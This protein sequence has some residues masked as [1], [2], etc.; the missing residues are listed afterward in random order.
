VKC[1]TRQ[2][3]ISKTFASKAL[4]G[5]TGKIS[6]SYNKTA[7]AVVGLGDKIFSHFKNTLNF[8]SGAFSGIGNFA[9]S[10]VSVMHEGAGT[11]AKN[12]S[13]CI[14]GK[15]SEFHDYTWNT[16]R[17][18]FEAAHK[19][20]NSFWNYLSRLPGTYYRFFKNAA[21]SVFSKITY[22][23]TVI[24]G[25]FKDM[26]SMTKHIVH[27]VQAFSDKT[28]GEI[29]SSIDMAKKLVMS[30]FVKINNLAANLFRDKKP[31][32]T[33][34]KEIPVPVLAE[35]K[36]S[37]ITDLPDI[38]P[39]AGK[40]DQNELPDQNYSVQVVLV[41]NRDA[42]ISS[43]MNGNIASIPYE[44]GTSFNK[45]DI[46]VRFD[47][48]MQKAVYRE[49]KAAADLAKTELE[50]KKQ[51]LD[52]GSLSR[53]ELLAAKG[54][55][56]QKR[57][58]MDQ[59]ATQLTNCAVTAPFD[60]RVTEHL[61]SAYEYAERGRTLIEISAREPLRAQFLVPS[62]WLRWLNIDT[63]LDVYVE[64]SGKT[65]DAKIIRIHGKV[66]PVSQTV[67]IVAEMERYDEELL[68]GM[69]GR[70][71]FDPVKAV[72]AVSRGFLGLRIDNG[73]KFDQQT[74]PAP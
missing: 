9:A 42:V 18:A 36:T 70:A 38:E 26:I 49:R 43:P 44:N 69:S 66:D 16:A 59:A 30:P 53:I 65:Y 33:T 58:R 61:A 4:I 12:A 19:G 50:A 56:D 60:G 74:E 45:N 71:I 47:C 46:L 1:C 8:A 37:E 27:G 63:P 29:R 22:A 57:A 40:D 17:G 10:A 23:G 52:M 24:N 68:P 72:R 39:A 11:F 55:Y 25:G 13:A 3:A 5:I 41:S 64:E 6:N 62:R 34:E 67:G 48:S 35:N 20:V 21:G 31:T 14:S 54:D 15:L 73:F 2:A 7:Y 32:E 28:T 51:L